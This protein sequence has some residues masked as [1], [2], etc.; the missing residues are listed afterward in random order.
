[1]NIK[2]INNAINLLER[3]KSINKVDRQIKKYWLSHSFTPGHGYI[4]GLRVAINAYD[5]AKKNNYK[6]PSVAFIAGLLHDTSRPIRSEAGQEKHAKQSGKIAEEILAGIN[7]KEILIKEIRQ[8]ISNHENLFDRNKNF[9]KPLSLLDI[10]LY[11]ADKTDMNLERCLIYGVISDL[12]NLREREI[13]LYKNIDKVTGDLNAKLSGNRDILFCIKEKFPEIEGVT[14]AIHAHNT[15][16]KNFTELL[17]K[18][19]WNYQ[20]YVRM[21]KQLTEQNILENQTLIANKF[22]PN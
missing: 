19:K 16:M 5:L 2:N 18:E 20:N 8:A 17:K 9:K 13:P 15:T 14:E 21:A 1:M 6:N 4:H 10:I 3:D 7:F 12:N 11:L 22:L